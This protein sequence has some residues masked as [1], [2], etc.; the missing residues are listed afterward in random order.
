[1]LGLRKRSRSDIPTPAAGS[2][3]LTVDTSGLLVFKKED[4]SVVAPETLISEL[5]A[6]VAANAEAGASAVDLAGAVSTIDAAI[7]LKQDAASA[8]TDSE[9]A[10]EKTARET[11]DAL[12]LPKAG[13]TMTGA[14]TLSGDPTNNLHA[15]TKQ[16]VVAQIAALVNGAPGALDTLKEISDRLELDESAEATLIGTIATKLA[17]ASNL[18]DI[19]NSATALANLG[20]AST[21]A[22]TAEETRAK[23]AE[24]SV[25]GE[26]KTEKER[27][28]AA[29][30]ALL[31]TT[32]KT[33]A[34]SGAS[35]TVALSEGRLWDV[36]L[37]AACTITLPAPVKGGSLT[38]FLRQGPGGPWT[39]TWAGTVKWGYGSAPALTPS[40]E[41]IDVVSFVSPDG[42]AWYGFPGGYE[43]K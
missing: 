42:T 24:S 9:L 16:F 41:A 23:A 20:G 18:S 4:G 3:Y 33:V 32:A 43:F 39:V 8:A 22:L 13:G 2:V 11:A 15:A 10:S 34:V 38:L 7:A 6:T 37:T 12:A 27:A 1:M 40:A 5:A 14:L 35:Q 29:E 36:T 17:K 21:T 28:E 30:A 31:N 25:K 19:A 26:V